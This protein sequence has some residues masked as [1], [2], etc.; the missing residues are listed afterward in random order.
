[1]NGFRIR[2][3][4]SCIKDR[5]RKDGEGEVDDGISSAEGPLYLSIA[6]WLSHGFL[7]MLVDCLCSRFCPPGSLADS[8]VLQCNLNKIPSAQVSHL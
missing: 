4:P 1:M 5:A 6:S 3:F 7:E 2:G 8:I